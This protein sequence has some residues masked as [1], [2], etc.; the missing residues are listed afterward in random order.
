MDTCSKNLKNKLEKDKQLR[1][2]VTSAEGE[3]G[4]GVVQTEGFTCCYHDLFS[5]WMMGT[6]VF[7]ILFSVLFLICLKYG[8][9]IPYPKTLESSLFQN[10]EL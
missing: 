7:I 1:I 5:H 6:Q 3:K 2:A 10:L 4:W 8:S 9:T